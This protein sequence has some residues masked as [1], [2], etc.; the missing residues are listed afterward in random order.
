MII[1]EQTC[2]GARLKEASD[3]AKKTFIDFFSFSK[4]YLAFLLLLFIS[5]SKL[6]SPNRRL[7][8]SLMLYVT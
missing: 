8:I 5:Q 3:K 7:E 2:L 4:K 1:E 6:T